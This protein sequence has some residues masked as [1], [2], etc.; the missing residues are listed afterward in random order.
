MHGP[1]EGQVAAQADGQPGNSAITRGDSRKVGERL[2]GVHVP[3]VTSVDDGDAEV[4]GRAGRHERSAFLGVT[5]RDD[6]DEIGHGFHG[7]GDGFA[8]GHGGQLGAGETNHMAAEPEHRRFEAQTRARAGLIK[9]GGQHPAVAGMRHLMTMRFDVLRFME[10]IDNLGCRQIVKR[11]HA[12]AD[13]GRCGFLRN[14]VCRQLGAEFRQG[15]PS[16]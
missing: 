10:Q 4:L 15:S 8:L 1:P 13:H 11:D 9:K 3:A 12:F 2:G 7:V 6:V 14:A 16:C 5:H